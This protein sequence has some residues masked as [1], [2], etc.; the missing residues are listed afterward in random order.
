MVAEM[1]K[2]VFT[3]E[4]LIT[5]IDAFRRTNND[6]LPHGKIAQCQPTA[7]GAIIVGVELTY[8]HSSQVTS[9]TLNPVDLLDPLVKFC[10]ENNVILPLSGRKSIKVDR[11][12]ITLFISIENMPLG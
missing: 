11:D 9:F 3:K 12:Q 7:D 8:G 10:I 6:F 4:E 2:I 1:R 5:A